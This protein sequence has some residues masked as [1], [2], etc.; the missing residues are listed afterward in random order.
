[1]VPV[2]EEIWRQMGFTEAPILFSGLSGLHI[3]RMAGNSFNQ[4]CFVAWVCLLL[5]KLKPASRG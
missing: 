4:A 5:S 3:K 2:Y 1:M